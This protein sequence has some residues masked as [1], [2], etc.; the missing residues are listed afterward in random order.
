MTTAIPDRRAALAPR[1]FPRPVE[2]RQRDFEAFRGQETTLILLNLGLIV[3]LL[4]VQVGFH[5][6]LGMP[7]SW[8]MLLFGG[9]FIM[10]AA[11][12]LLLHNVSKPWARAR[13]RLYEHGSIAAHLLF[14]AAASFL[15]MKEDSHYT[16][17]LV[18]PVVAAAFRYRL[19]GALVVA[20]IG[21]AIS[22]IEVWL[23]GAM[24]SLSEYFEAFTMGLVFLLVSAIVHVLVRQLEHEQARRQEALEELALTREQLVQEEKLGLI[25]RLASAVAHEIRNPIAMISSSLLAAAENGS[26]PS[27]QQEMFGIASEEAA[28]LERFTG[29]FLAYARAAAPRRELVDLCTTLRYVAGLARAQAQH[30]QV[31]ISVTCGEH[32]HVL[33]DAYQ[34][35]QALL[36]LVKNALDATAPGGRVALRG[37]RNGERVLLHVENEGSPIAEATAV[38]LFEPFFTT[39]RSGTGLGLGI[40]ENTAHA[41]GGELAL[42]ANG[43]DRVCFTMSIPAGAAGAAEDGDMPDH[44]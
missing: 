40:A 38:R 34:L 14:A 17:L 2:T 13:I 25:G 28:R 18:L 31:T 11:E 33:A 8:L 10:Q 15:S 1:L 5:D 36:N 23:G 41:H 42:T 19:A 37:E 24:N 35:Q 7:D 20:G 30:G 3:A 6:A 9:R 44:G 39:K 27:L 29:D 12:L 4:A 32:L 43:P 26:D 16:V 21:A 22:L